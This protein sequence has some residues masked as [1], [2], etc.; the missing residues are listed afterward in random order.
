[1]ALGSAAAAE[2]CCAREDAIS[3][4]VADQEFVA[5][6]FDAV[7]HV[8]AEEAAPALSTA[9]SL[10]NTVSAYAEHADMDVEA[11]QVLDASGAAQAEL[12]VGAGEDAFVNATLIGNGLRADG[13][14]A[15]VEVSADQA[16]TGGADGYEASATLTAETAT[17]VAV[18]AAATA[19]AVSTSTNQGFVGAWS[20]Q[21][22]IGEVVATSL[23]TAD[24]MTGP[25]LVGAQATGNAVTNT[26]RGGYWGYAEQSAEGARIQATTDVVAGE[27][28]DLT[29]T[30]TG[31]GNSVNIDQLN[32]AIELVADQAN[33][34]YV[35]GE[36]YVTVNERGGELNAA[37]T[38]FGNTT[39]ASGVGGD[40]SLVIDQVNLGG[41]VDAVTDLTSFAGDGGVS[42]SAIA[43]G[44]A[45]S[46]VVCST[47]ERVMTATTSQTN[48]ASVFA[49]TTV[50]A[51]G[52]G[53][54]SGSAVA[55]GNAAT[56]E[57]RRPY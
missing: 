47:C 7:A 52:S 5:E 8:T 37:S 54:V 46:G 18:N 56:F 2:D 1:M 22:H 9:T 33:A 42:G 28:E 4:F 19:N 49:Q 39:V 11:R 26:S 10:A 45:I 40:A 20:R 32:G 57:I 16:S 3:V 41:G 15:S 14:C 53:A 27:T 43:Y 21:T 38:A 29:A 34:A 36:T 55:I 51:G 25:A 17:N 13:C 44:N 31:T 30:A 6:R 48:A 50:N 23:V 12:S 35:R 24:E